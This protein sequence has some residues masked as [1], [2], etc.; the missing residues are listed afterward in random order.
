MQM[1]RIGYC[2]VDC[3][4]CPDYRTGTCPGCRQSSWPEGD[5]CPPVSCCRERRIDC[6]GACR[7]FPCEMMRDF[8]GESE[9][10]ER[11]YL[12]MTSLQQEKEK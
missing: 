9:S 11:A 8:Y 12:L 5:A 6:C 7:D 3:A 4:P 1:E 10:H 2:G